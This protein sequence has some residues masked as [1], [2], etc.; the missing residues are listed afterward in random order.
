MK[1]PEELVEDYT[2]ALPERKLDVFDIEMAFL[3]G[4]K[5][6]YERGVEATHLIYDAVQE[7]LEK[8][9]FPVV[10]HEPLLPKYLKVEN[11]D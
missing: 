5:A 4:Y 10:E 1:T 9:M 3:A 2:S 8:Q 6:G 7:H 11:K